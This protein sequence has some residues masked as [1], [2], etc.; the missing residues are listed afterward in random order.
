[1]VK[2]YR[3]AQTYMGML[4]AASMLASILLFCF[5]TYS[6]FWLHPAPIGLLEGALAVVLVVAA[7]AFLSRK[8]PSFSF[9]L[10]LAVEFLWHGNRWGSLNES[11][12]IVSLLLAVNVVVAKA[13]VSFVIKPLAIS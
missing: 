10:P 1:M 6:L 13:V 12:V 5:L 9:V 7:W 8:A 3:R 2:K 11:A 4:V